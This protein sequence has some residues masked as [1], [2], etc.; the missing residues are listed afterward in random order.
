M[1]SHITA[2]AQSCLY[3]SNCAA[4]V[5]A[6]ICNIPSHSVC[7]ALSAVD[8]SGQV[9]SKGRDM[10]AMNPLQHAVMAI[11]DMA[12]AENRRHFSDQSLAEDAGVE[13]G[14]T[15]LLSMAIIANATQ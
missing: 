6:L 14:N 9:V 8:F 7:V 12:A 1:A 2:I 10:T 15:L 4:Q 5:D 13:P 11:I 3:H